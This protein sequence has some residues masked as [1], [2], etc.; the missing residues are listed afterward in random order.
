M[1][2]E[3]LEYV[4]LVDLLEHGLLCQNHFQT[5]FVEFHDSFIQNLGVEDSPSL[6][7]LKQINAQDCNVTNIITE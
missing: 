5:I 6:D 4:V 2:L 3:G 7:L 1:D